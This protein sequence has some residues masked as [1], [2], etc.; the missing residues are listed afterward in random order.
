MFTRSPLALASGGY[1]LSC[2][3]VIGLGIEIAQPPAH[4]LYNQ[5]VIVC[6]I[7]CVT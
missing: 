3:G 1:Y 2:A 4:F 7:E 6:S 5:G